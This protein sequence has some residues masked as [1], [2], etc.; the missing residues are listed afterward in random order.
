MRFD[1]A[2]LDRLCAD[3][4]KLY[5]NG[6][7]AYSCILMAFQ[8]NRTFKRNGTKQNKTTEVDGSTSRFWN[9]II[10]SNFWKLP[11]KFIKIVLWDIHVSWKES[12]P[13]R[14]QQCWLIPPTNQCEVLSV[15]SIFQT[16]TW[17]EKIF[18]QKHKTRCF[19]CSDNHLID[20]PGESSQWTA[21][22]TIQ[23]GE[24]LMLFT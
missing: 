15:A 8:M 10:F 11:Y 3:M 13:L 14:R 19:R 16:T 5:W 9:H 7:K 4:I 2:W 17:L 21:T 22:S 1:V 20:F 6:W 18:R 23:R 12:C 24:R